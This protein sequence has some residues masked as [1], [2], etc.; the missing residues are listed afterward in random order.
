ML[1]EDEIRMGEDFGLIM[2][3][4]F[5]FHAKFEIRFR[6]MQESVSGTAEQLESTSEWIVAFT[7]K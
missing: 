5:I 3:R 2:Y 6:T 7:V 4:K 1:I